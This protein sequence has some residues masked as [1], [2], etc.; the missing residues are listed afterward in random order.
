MSP[1]NDQILQKIIN[2]DWLLIPEQPA[3]LSEIFQDKLKQLQQLNHLNRPV[4]ILIAQPSPVEF[5]GSFCGAIAHSQ[6]HIF[7]GNHHWQK[8]EW[9]QVLEIV[10]PDLIWGDIGFDYDPNYYLDENQINPNLPELL[11][12]IAT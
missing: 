12:M 1:I 4:R 6:S 8:S 3:S 11:I 7:L 10:K 2:P 5:L 9:Q